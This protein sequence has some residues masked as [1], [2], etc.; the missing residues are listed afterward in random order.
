MEVEERAGRGG[1]GPQAGLGCRGRRLKAAVRERARAGDVKRVGLGGQ[2]GQVSP[3]P[4]PPFKL[5]GAAPGLW[6]RAPSLCPG[7]L[8]PPPSLGTEPR[9]R[10][11]VGGGGAIPSWGQ[12]VW[13]ALS[14]LTGPP[15]GDPPLWGSRGWAVGEVEEVGAPSWLPGGGRGA[16]GECGWAWRGGGERGAGRAAP[17]VGAAGGDCPARAGEG[18]AAAGPG[19]RRAGGAGERGGRRLGSSRPSPGSSPRNRP[20]QLLAGAA[21]RHP[22]PPAPRAPGSWLPLPPPPRPRRRRRRGG[23]ARFGVGRPES[24]AKSDER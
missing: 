1:A 2:V 15:C 20:R 11:W 21:S 10:G 4:F 8:L 22:S 9:K 13:E 19:A 16:R 17:G 5:H 6:E 24:A 12:G 7:L 18:R 14:G 3:S 23:P